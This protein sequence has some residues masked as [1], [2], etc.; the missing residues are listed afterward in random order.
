ME[1]TSYTGLYDYEIDLNVTTAVERKTSGQFDV[2]MVLQMLISSV[3]IVANWAVVFA[4]LNHKQLRGKIPN[5]F[6]INQV[7]KCFRLYTIFVFEDHRLN[8][9]SLINLRSYFEIHHIGN[10]GNIGIRG[11]TT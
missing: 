5:M 10:N 11:F 7:S 6:I 9:S 4:F 8:S 2:M 1:T 3:G